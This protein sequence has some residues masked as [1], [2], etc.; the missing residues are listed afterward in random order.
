V[1]RSRAPERVDLLVI[2]GGQAGLAMSYYLTQ[3]GREH[4]VIERAE[5]AER[6]RTQ[7]WDSLMS[8][9]PNWSI[10]LPSYS[11]SGDDP[12]GFSHKDAIRDFIKAYAAHIRAPVR[13][14]T[15]VLELRRANL[16]GRYH[17]HTDHG[18]LETH[19]VVIATGPYQRPRI[20]KLSAA[21][22]PDIL[23][24]HASVYR[25]PAA[26]PAGPVLVVGSG[27][28][29]CQIADELL[30][31]G[32]RVYLSVGRHTRL[33][34]R[35]RGKDVFW[36]LSA[37]GW[38]EAI[39]DDSPEALRAARFLVTGVRG[40][41]DIDLRRSA[42]H[43][44]V[45]LGHLADVHDGRLVLKPDVEESL[46]KGDDAFEAFVR[47]VDDHVRRTGSDA[48]ESLNP[49]ERQKG[50]PIDE[51]RDLDLRAT[52]IRS[53]IWAT[54]Y[55]LDYGWVDLP[56][57]DARGEPIQRRGVTIAPGVYFLGLK[58]QYKMKSSLLCGV[59]EDAAYL[60]EQLARSGPGA[61]GS[62]SDVGDLGR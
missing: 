22:P 54:G 31:S 45:L 2:G 23:Q 62:A 26:L 8:Q 52:G 16:P 53:I 60:A 50:G 59:G 46:R 28:S 17:V 19:G 13:T 61:A 41:Y 58:R 35:Y 4:L 42:D 55:A 36:W 12:N 38:Y 15:N 24:L 7:R 32:R 11:Y 20:S 34:R 30:E 51:I 48:P 39:V 18:D 43:G 40:G 25:S 44:M 14:A 56:V 5:V 21:M 27:A 47:A 37:L 29:G 6:W 3:I 57:F 9:F 10:E 49:A 33:P 1:S